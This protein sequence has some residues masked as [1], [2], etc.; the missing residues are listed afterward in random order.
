[1]LMEKEDKEFGD[2]FSDEPEGQDNKE[3]NDGEK[4]NDATNADGQGTGAEDAQGADAEQKPVEEGLPDEVESK[5][6]KSDETLPDKPKETEPDWKVK[7]ET[8]EAKAADLE[9]RVKDNQAAFTKSQQELADLKKR[10][11]DLNAKLEEKDKSQVQAAAD[12]VP[13]NVKA[14]FD[15]YEGSQDAI[16]F[17]AQSLAE[18]KIKE[19]R[20]SLGDLDEL[21]KVKEI[22]DAV[23]AEKWE[24]SVVNGFIDSDGNYIAGVPDFYRIVAPSNKEY[25]DWYEKKGYGLC[26]PA[27]AIARLNEWKMTKEEQRLIAETTERDRAAAEKATKAQEVLKASLP[28]S[29]RQPKAPVKPDENDFEGG[30]ND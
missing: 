1:M 13:D 21:K 2:A 22:Q 6:K 4:T 15:D 14:F 29:Q 20:E 24:R 7:A 18:K 19:F 17:L 26:E 8:A 9:K 3:K 23:K 5:D 16:N 10:L 30:F 11:D 12:V 28:S 27:D 25:W